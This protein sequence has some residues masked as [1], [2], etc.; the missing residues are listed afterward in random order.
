MVDRF[1]PEKEGGGELL[2][3]DESSSDDDEKEEQDGLVFRLSLAMIAANSVVAQHS[4]IL[5]FVPMRF[6][7]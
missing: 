3:T 2:A 7:L 4:L 5:L 6:E 1:R